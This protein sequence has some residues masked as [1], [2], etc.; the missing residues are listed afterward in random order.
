VQP[1]RQVSEKAQ[2]QN[3]FMRR[4]G[5][6]ITPGWIR[7]SSRA[8]PR[9]STSE[10]PRTWHP[11]PERAVAKPSCSYA[12]EVFPQRDRRPG[13]TPLSAGIESTKMPAESAGDGA[14]PP[15]AH[16]NHRRPGPRPNDRW[17]TRIPVLEDE[18]FFAVP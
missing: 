1:A 18:R 12:D 16:G 2:R 13:P 17:V 8:S 3:L 9:A 15:A 5:Q 10:L 6:L 7:T 14:A 11:H 4:D